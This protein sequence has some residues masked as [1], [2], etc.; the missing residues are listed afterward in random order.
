MGVVASI[1]FSDLPSQSASFC[2]KRGEECPSRVFFR[3]A[4]NEGG[5]NAGLPIGRKRQGLLEAT[6]TKITQPRADKITRL[7]HFVDE[8]G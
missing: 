2:C 7:A 6:Q 5:W 4:G 3:D 1:Q 8:G